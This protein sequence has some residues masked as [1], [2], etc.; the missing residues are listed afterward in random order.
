MATFAAYF[1]HT[2]GRSDIGVREHPAN[3]FGLNETRETFSIWRRMLGIHHVIPCGRS[4]FVI[5]GHGAPLS[6]SED[7]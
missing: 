2:V 7:E 1:Q 3:A 5:L 6:P 4:N